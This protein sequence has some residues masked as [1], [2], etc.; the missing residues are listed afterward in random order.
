VFSVG[1][2][3]GDGNAETL[4]LGYEQ[5]GSAVDYWWIVIPAGAS[6]RDGIAIRPPT[7]RGTAPVVTAV[8]DL[9][10]DGADDLMI[11]T[12]GRAEAAFTLELTDEVLAGGLQPSRP[13]RLAITASWC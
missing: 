5:V 3:D 7:Q 8:G 4:V 12:T 2:L 11:S 1:D 13:T 9:N 10:G 6:E